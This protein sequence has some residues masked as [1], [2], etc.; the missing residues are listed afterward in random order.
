MTALTGLNQEGKTSARCLDNTGPRRF[1]V[2]EQDS[3][4]ADE[5]AAIIMHLAEQA[6]LVLV[7][8]SGGKSLHSWFVCGQQPESTLRQFFDAAVKLG[9]DPAMWVRCQL[10]RMPDGSRPQ[11]GENVRQAVLYWNPDIIGAQA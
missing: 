6:P 2:V 9:A 1:L 4:T 7:V 10:A 11:H 5:Q 3:G 8:H